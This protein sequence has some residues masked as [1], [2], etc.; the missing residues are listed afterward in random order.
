M[1]DIFAGVICESF[2]FD[3]RFYDII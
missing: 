2:T 1:L 3:G